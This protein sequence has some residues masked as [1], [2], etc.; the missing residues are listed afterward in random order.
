M[1]KYHELLHAMQTGVEYRQNK[2]DQEPKHLRVGI[3]AA[4][5][6][7]G[8]LVALLIEKGIITAEEHEAAITASMQREVD[9]YRQHIAEE[10]GADPSTIKLA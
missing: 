6:D 4:M 9:A 3:N 2:R 8:G 1:S 5:S 10:I 7:Y